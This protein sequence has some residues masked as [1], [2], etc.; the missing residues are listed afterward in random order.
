MEKAETITVVLLN[1]N[2]KQDTLECLDS[3]S[4]INQDNFRLE[5]IVA[6]NASQDNSVMEI[7]TNFPQV[8][9]LENNKN[10]GFCR[11]N[12]LAVNKAF[13]QGADYVFILNNDTLVSENILAELIKAVKKEKVEIASPKIYF[14]PGFEFHKNRYTKKDLGKVIWY[15]GGNIDWNNVLPQHRGVNEVDKG[16]YDQIETTDFLTGCAMLVSR[17]AYAQLGLFDE[18]YFAYFEDADFSTRAW[19]NNF[20]PMY[21]P[22]AFLWHKNASSFGGSGSPFQDYFMTRNRLIF[23]LRFAP[24]RVKLALLKQYLGFLISGSGVRKR[25]VLDGLLK[26]MTPIGKIR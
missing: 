4:R 15:A 18:T 17:K 11:G 26:R 5:I 12:N 6:D 16:Q 8:K 20:K 13:S 3:L 2:G 25:A 9:V 24:R 21:I 22:Q 1:F 19:K 10:L 14:A 7:K 23:G